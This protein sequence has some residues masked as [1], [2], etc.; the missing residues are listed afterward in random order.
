MRGI[1]NRG[2]TIIEVLLFLAIS[3]MM[4]AVLLVSITGGINRERYR[5]AVSSFTDFMQGQYN[6][7]DNVRNNRITAD[8]CS[9]SNVNRATSDCTIIGRLVVGDV[10]GTRVTSYPVITGPSVDITA[11]V[12]TG[13]TENDYIKSL[14]LEPID[15]DSVEQYDLTWQTT[16]VAPDSTDKKPFSLL[17]IRSPLSSAM[18]TYY[19]DTVTSD[20]NVIIDTAVSEKTALCLEPSGLVMSSMLGVLIDPASVSSAAIQPATAEDC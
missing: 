13:I 17:I 4:A 9:A 20:P 11:P 3:G 7:A 6:L 8:E 10:E 2:F 18:K 15:N 16:I 5:D 14:Q 12:P 19:T 1:K